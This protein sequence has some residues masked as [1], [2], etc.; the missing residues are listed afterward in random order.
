M[1]NIET[2]KNLPSL[3]TFTNIAL[4]LDMSPAELFEIIKEQGILEEII[5]K[6]N[7]PKKS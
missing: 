5:K 2:G 6:A 3:E 4:N 1:S 7:K